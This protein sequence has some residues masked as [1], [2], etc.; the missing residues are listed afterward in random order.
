LIVSGD[1]DYLT[2]LADQKKLYQAIKGSYHVVLPGVGHA[3]MYEVPMLFTT[4]VLGFIN[5]KDTVY[6][7]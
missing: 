2:P 7:V 5:A 6:T 1:E 3:S 4:L